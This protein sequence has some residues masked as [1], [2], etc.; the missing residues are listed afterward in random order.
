MI[1]AGVGEL[2]PEPAPTTPGGD[3][4]VVE[5]DDSVRALISCLLEVE[6]H[7]VRTARDG[8]EALDLIGERVPDLVT[9]DVMM[10]GMDGRELA[11]RLRDDPISA[12][13][14]RVI[15]SANVTDSAGATDADA[16]ACL[17][18]PFDFA[19]LCQ[20]VNEQLALVRAQS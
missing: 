5:D 16:H 3:V 9:I 20:V 1:N 2:P 10:P 18:K 6:G 14:R 7:T 4:L 17:G 8:Y 11:A 19:T 13:V 15:V 12:H